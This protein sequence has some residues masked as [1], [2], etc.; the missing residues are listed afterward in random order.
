M[1]CKDLNSCVHQSVGGCRR[2]VRLDVD[3]LTDT[4]YQSF[5]LSPPRGILGTSRH[6]I[7]TPHIPDRQPLKGPNARPRRLSAKMSALVDLLWSVQGHMA[8]VVPIFSNTKVYLAFVVVVCIAVVNTISTLMRPATLPPRFYYLS[9][10]LRGKFNMK[11]EGPLG[12]VRAGSEEL[13]DIFTCHMFHKRITFL[14]GPDAQSVLF[15]AKDDVVEQQAVYKFTVPVFGHGVVYDAPLKVMNQ[16]L[17]FL[18][19]GLAANAMRQHGLKII[20]ETEAFFA[21]WKEEGVIPFQETF[22]NLIIR[23]ASRCLLGNEVRE[24]IHDKVAD[25]FEELNNGMTPISF[26]F[27]YLP[28]A[29]H[30]RRDHA[31]VELCK[32]FE[33]TINARRQNPVTGQDFDLCSMLMESTY[34]DGKKLSNQE[35]SGLLLAALFAGQ[36]TSTITSTWTGLLI[37]SNKKYLPRL[38]EEQKKAFAESGGKLTFEAISQMHLLENCAMEALRMFPPLILLMRKVNKPLQYGKYIIP[39]ED[40]IISSPSVSHR[41][42]SVYTNPD[43]FDPDRY[44]QGEGDAKK[45]EYIAFGGGRHACLGQKF[46]LLQVKSI[47]SYLI[48]HYTFELVDPFPVVDYQ[49]MVAGP[50]GAGPNG[51]V[52]VKYTR[53]ETPLC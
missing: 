31:R 5:S 19:H 33:T 4:R 23:T 18:K 45:M 50:K 43:T 44:D 13:G 21:D 53:R 14:V 3:K 41:L 48:R 2:K 12:L 29:A 30:K 9:K 25:L 26:F 24:Q 32:L 8:S 52:R 36:H 37:W 28:I 22:N 39:E 10:M 51:Q 20:K 40:V 42:K 35:I 15:N 38:E 11:N 16:Q 49:S 1:G 6:I 46:G 17:R 47:W 34:S 7:A 27:P